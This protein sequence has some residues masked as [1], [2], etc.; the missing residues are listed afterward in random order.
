[1]LRTQNCF[2]A[3]VLFKIAYIC[4]CKVLNKY[5]IFKIVDIIMAYEI[6]N[7][8]ELCLAVFQVLDLVKIMSFL[9]T[10]FL[11]LL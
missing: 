1:M 4:I 9:T 3:Q 8:Y 6:K 10:T 5:L 11:P 2:V 7:N